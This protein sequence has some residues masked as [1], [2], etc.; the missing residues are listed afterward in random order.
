MSFYY[1]RNAVGQNVLFLQY[2]PAVVITV[3]F[4]TKALGGEEIERNH[5]AWGLVSDEEFIGAE[6]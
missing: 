1:V 4:L 2:R 3:D 6:K 5:A